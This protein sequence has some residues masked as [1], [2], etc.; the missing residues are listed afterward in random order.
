VSNYDFMPTLLSYLG[1]KE[2]MAKTPESPGR[3]Y[4]AVLRGALPAWESVVFFEY[5]NT[6]MIRTDRWKLTRRFPEGP[7]ELYDLAGDPGEQKNLIDQPAQ[8]ATQRG[9]QTRL[10][11]FFERYADLRYDLWRDGESK[12]PLVSMRGRRTGQP[13]VSRPSTRPGRSGQ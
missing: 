8:A 5:E 12:A 10:E 4:S 3:D 6:R 1:L 13:A 9:L 7:H 2:R 11:Q